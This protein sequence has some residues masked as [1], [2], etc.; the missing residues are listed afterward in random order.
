VAAEPVSNHFSLTTPRYFADAAEDVTHVVRG[1]IPDGVGQVTAF[2]DLIAHP[3]VVGVFSDPVI[4]TTIVCPGDPA[5]GSDA[6][7]AKQLR[8]TALAGKGMDGTGVTVA[9]VDTGFNLAYLK[10]KGRTLK[11]SAA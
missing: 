4:E 11:F 5:V 9:I 10:S 8:T 7:V 6:D 2:A 1:V 3:D